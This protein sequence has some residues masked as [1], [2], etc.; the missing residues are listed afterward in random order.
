[1]NLGRYDDAEAMLR[2][3]PLRIGADGRDTIALHLAV[4]RKNLAAIRWLLAHGV[5]VDAKRLMWDCNHTAL[6][7]TVENGAIEIARL[8]LD[9][10]ADPQIRDDKYHATALGWA[11]FFDRN[12]IAALI[13]ERGGTP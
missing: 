7:M 13:R 8:L 1:V 6:H 10:G 4:S 5:S 2:Q 11:E 9:A 12:D 3:D